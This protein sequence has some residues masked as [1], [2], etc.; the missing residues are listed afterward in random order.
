MNGTDSIDTYFYVHT[1]SAGINGR[2]S[3]LE[4]ERIVVPGSALPITRRRD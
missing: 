1:L 2:L 4:P 3:L